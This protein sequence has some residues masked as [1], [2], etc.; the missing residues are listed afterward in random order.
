MQKTFD[1]M[2]T[3]CGN[4][5]LHAVDI[6]PNRVIPANIVLEPNSHQG[7]A[8]VRV[9][10]RDEEFN[11]LWGV[12]VS[13]GLM[14][15]ESPTPVA[16]YGRLREMIRENL[17]D[18]APRHELTKDPFVALQFCL[19]RIRDMLSKCEKETVLV[20]KKSD[21]T[22]TRASK[23]ADILFDTLRQMNYDLSEIGILSPS[24]ATDTEKGK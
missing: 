10:A 4:A 24:S 15:A 14:P 23:V 7:V 9:T 18:P 17:T 22:E 19:S 21:V 6:S 12:N 11:L 16:F 8:R 2:L 20:K 13:E 3:E 5:G 1:Q